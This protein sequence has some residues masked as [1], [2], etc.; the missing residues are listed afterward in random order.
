MLKISLGDNCLG[1]GFSTFGSDNV[2][3]PFPIMF[4][5]SPSMPKDAIVLAADRCPSL[6]GPASALAPFK[7]P[8]KTGVLELDTPSDPFCK[9]SGAEMDLLLP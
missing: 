7:N 9:E 5:P 6:L 2:K 4:P 1:D 3:F 8:P